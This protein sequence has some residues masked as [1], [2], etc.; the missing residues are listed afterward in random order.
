MQFDTASQN[1]FLTVNPM[2]DICNEF[3]HNPP[4]LRRKGEVED[5]WL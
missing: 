5:L 4:F 1:Y 2:I 3:S